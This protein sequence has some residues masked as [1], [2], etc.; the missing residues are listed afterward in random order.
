MNDDTKDTAMHVIV[1]KDL[2]LS[3]WTGDRCQYPLGH[4]GPHS[5][6]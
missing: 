2:C 3:G 6:P 5:N 1:V 4:D